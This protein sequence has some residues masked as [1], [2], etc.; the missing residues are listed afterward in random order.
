MNYIILIYIIKLSNIVEKCPLLTLVAKIWTLYFD[1]FS[2]Q[3]YTFYDFIVNKARGKSGPLFNFDVHEDIRLT[4]DAT[5]EKD[6][7]RYLSCREISCL[8]M[9][10]FCCYPLHAQKP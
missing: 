6:E 8:F 5:I 1:L 9:L 4:N 7:V 3:H 10:I 2:I